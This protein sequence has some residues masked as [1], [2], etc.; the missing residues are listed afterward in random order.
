[1]RP[2]TAC[3]GT[4]PSTRGSSTPSGRTAPPRAGAGRRLRHRRL[5][6][7]AAAGAAHRR[8]GR[9]RVQPDAAARARAKAG[10][11]VAAG[12]VNA[13]P[14]AD[15]AFGS[16]VSLDVLCH[17]AVEPTAR[18]PEFHRVLRPG[19]AARVEPARLPVAVF[20]ARR[21]RHT[22]RRFTAEDVGALLAAAGLRGGP[23]ALLE[24]APVPAHGLAAQGPGPRPGQRV[25]RVLA[26][27]LAEP[28][29][30]R[31]HGA[32]AA[33]RGG[34]PALPRRRLRARHATRPEFPHP[35]RRQSRPH[36]R[37]PGTRRTAAR[38]PPPGRRAARP[39]ARRRDRGRPRPG[40]GRAGRAQHR[41]AGVPR[42]RTVAGWWR[43]SRRCAR[44]AGWRSSW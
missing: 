31:R 21:P 38:S 6:R 22:R 13:V 8:R 43:R 28:G 37:I 36:G 40:R 44:R 17:A 42:R 5:S 14:F 11:P 3:G 10:V 39:D 9:A 1:M 25:R 20:G 18:W 34:G 23:G 4:A 27:A 29:L 15:A 7:A 16:L 35:T 26:A 33:G 19:G 41:G 30:P 2:R 12:S 32:G 24:L